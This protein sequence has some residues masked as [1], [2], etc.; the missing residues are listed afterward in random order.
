MVV[1]VGAYISNP[2]IGIAAYI[3]EFLR[4]HLPVDKYLRGRSIE[5]YLTRSYLYNGVVTLNHVGHVEVG[6]YAAAYAADH[7]T[8]GSCHRLRLQLVYL[9][10]RGSRLSDYYE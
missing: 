10:F 2:H 8:E 1:E 3:H 9:L 5:R 7:V 6:G 4:D